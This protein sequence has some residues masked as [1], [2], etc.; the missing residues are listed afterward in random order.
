MDS[1]AEY[2]D[3][4]PQS[5]CSID[6]HADNLS[7]LNNIINNEPSFVKREFSFAASEQASIT[8]T[9]NSQDDE[10]PA[11]PM[12]KLPETIMKYGR[13]KTRIK[14]SHTTVLFED[15]KSDHFHDVPALPK[16]PYP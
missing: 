11:P 8:G 9:S 13:P 2:L 15:I 4:L 10:R 16:A 12:P 6:K 1:P 3:H 5:F 14:A 7:L